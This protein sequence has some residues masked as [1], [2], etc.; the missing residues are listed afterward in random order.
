MPRKQHN[1]HYIYKTTCKVSG[2]YYIGMHS[3]SNIDDGYIGS[4]DR[5]RHSIRKHGKNNHV[6]EI[7]EFL[8]SRELLVERER[9]IV[10]LQL[11]QDKN[12]MNLKEGGEGGF[13]NEE[14]RNK[15]I[16]ASKKTT[17]KFLNQDEE[18]S[19]KRNAVSSSRL[20]QQ[21][22]DGIIKPF[23]WSGRTHSDETKK[24]ISE[25]KKGTGLGETNSQYG[26]CWITK[27]G[28]NK[29][30]KKELLGE[31]SVNGWVIGRNKKK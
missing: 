18:F 21:H 16:E 26:S 24:L 2:R 7:L 9:D 30:I 17:F 5:L 12:C 15:F 3:T 20:K 31:W 8:S 28:E 14:H 4:G 6:K 22:K 13:I 27:A 10:N 19:K 23:N 29:K 1:I 11:T 25:I